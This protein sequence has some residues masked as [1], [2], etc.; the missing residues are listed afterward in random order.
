MGAR[1][2]QLNIS[3]GG[4]PKLA[5]RDAE[6]TT[7]GLSGDD[8][9]FPDIHGGPDRAICLFSLEHIMKFQA[10]GHP[11]FPG[12]AGENVTISGIDWQQ[13]VPGAHLKLGEQV[14]IEITRY[15]TPCNS[16][17]PWFLDG[18]YRRL[19]QKS[20]PGFSRV[21]ARVLRTGRIAVGQDVQILDGL[22][23][24]LS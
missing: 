19:S 6:V 22:A 1:I 24:G 16:M 12:A 8:H 13:V 18:N 17:E 9:L 11:L 3:P 15:T 21:Y 7:L 2:F 20:N 14:V 5:V 4:V 10:E 23:D